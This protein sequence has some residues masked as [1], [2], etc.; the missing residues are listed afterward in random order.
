MNIWRYSRPWCKIKWLLLSVDS[1]NDIFF[2][3]FL[4][5]SNIYILRYRIVGMSSRHLF[6]GGECSKLI[7]DAI[8]FVKL[9]L[10]V[11]SSWSKGN[12]HCSFAAS[13]GITLPELKRE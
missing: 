9:V 1:C 2:S 6:S 5:L 10:V 4:L 11:N 3:S 12:N 13:G 7:I 8:F